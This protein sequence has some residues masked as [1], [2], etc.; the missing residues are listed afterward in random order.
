[1]VIAILAI[2]LV[3]RIY[4]IDRP[5]LWYD[6]AYAF[7]VATSSPAQII[8]VL[9]RDSGPPLYYFL[10]HYWITLFGE[11][12]LVTR[13]LSTLIGTGLVG[14]I[15]WAGQGLY[16]TQVGLLAALIAATSPVQ[17][18][19]SQQVRMYTLLPLVAMGSVYFLVRYLQSSRQKYIILCGV[20]TL[21]SF[22]THNF[23]LFLLP[24][25]AA[26]FFLDGQKQKRWKDLAVMYA[27]IGVGY[28]PWLPIFLIQLDNKDLSA[29][30]ATFW[31]RWGAL[32][33]IAWTLISFSSGGSQPPIVDGFKVPGLGR[34]GPASFFGILAV[35]GTLHLIR[36]R[37]ERDRMGA[38]CFPTYLIVPLMC[39]ALYSMFISPNYLAGRVDQMVFPAFCVIAA[40]GINAI[41]SWKVRWLIVGAALILSALTLKQLHNREF[42]P[43]ERDIGDFISERIQPG[44]PIVTTD[45]TRTSLTYYLRRH[46]I[47]PKMFSYPRDTARHLGYQN[48]L[49]LLEDPAYLAAEAQEI[50]DDMRSASGPAGRFFVVFANLTVNKPLLDKL[51]TTTDLK[52][53]GSD[54][55]MGR[56]WVSTYDIVVLRY[57]FTS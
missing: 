19:Y 22:Y 18:H 20:T 49:K 52:L 3:V 7:L 36:A 10:L 16:S 24:V 15:F 12:E 30:F 14:A 47:Q 55:Y 56:S 25:H 26:L 46:G 28:L 48:N 9:K 4:N 27:V 45:L 40:A 11:S 37:W 39:S 44:E 35:V 6:E 8:D 32:G 17:I 50:V 13:L 1:M 23:T 43:S 31:Q 38:L 57:R 34:I 42:G 2:A 51:A 5:P 41:P 54:L 21:L 33:A 29:W 53:E